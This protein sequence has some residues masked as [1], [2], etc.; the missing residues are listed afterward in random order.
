MTASGELPP[1]SPSFGAKLRAPAQEQ[2]LRA[3]THS[4]TEALEL[5]H[6]EMLSVFN[7]WRPSS[8]YR[9]SSGFCASPTTSRCP[10]LA[11]SASCVDSVY[12]ACGSGLPPVGGIPLRTRT[13]SVADELGCSDSC[14]GSA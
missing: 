1:I 8:P 14:P 3:R 10:P 13:A 11:P 5:L 4:H 12:L 2:L 6:S 9:T 7:I